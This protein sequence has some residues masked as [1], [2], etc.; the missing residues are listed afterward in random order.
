MEI[1]LHHLHE[2]EVDCNELTRL[3]Y[4]E[5]RKPA[6][7]P[8]QTSRSLHPLRVDEPMWARN[9]I[10]NMQPLVVSAFASRATLSNIQQRDHLRTDGG[11]KI[12][13]GSLYTTGLRDL[14]RLKNLRDLNIHLRSS[15]E[16]KSKSQ[17]KS[18]PKKLRLIH[19]G[20]SFPRRGR[21]DFDSMR[22][23]ELCR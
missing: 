3:D 2:V 23:R 14:H 15:S 5:L 22:K 17:P 6:L 4:G 7:R 11:E 13:N 10:Q 1:D 8:R 9:Y 12:P 18:C 16:F 20:A 21:T 19:L